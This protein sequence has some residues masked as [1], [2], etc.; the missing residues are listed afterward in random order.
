[1]NRQI[2]SNIKGFTLLEMLVVLVLV[3]LVSTLL[4]QGFSYVLHLRERFLQQL[5]DLQQGAIQEYWFRSSTSALIANYENAEPIFKGDSKQFS[6]LTLS[7]LDADGGVPMPM[8]WQL[9]YEYGITSLRYLH[10]GGETWQILQWQSDVGEFQYLSV[11]GEWHS[12]WP[13]ALG[14]QSPQLPRAILLTG[15]KRQSI[16]TWIVPILGRDTPP[17]DLNILW[18]DW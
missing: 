9:H 8:T 16:F 13:P 10:T 1:V 17:I 5:N 18:E 11:Q 12:E 14:D 4:L 6:G 7:A 2:S 15:Q 3:G